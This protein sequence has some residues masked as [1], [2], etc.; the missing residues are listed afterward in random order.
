MAMRL[1]PCHRSLR[2]KTTST[3]FYPKRPIDLLLNGSQKII[4]INTKAI[5]NFIELFWKRGDI[6]LSLVFTQT[7]I[8]GRRCLHQSKYC[9]SSADDNTIFSTQLL[10]TTTRRYQWYQ[11][12]CI[13]LTWNI[14]WTDIVSLDN[15]FI[16]GNQRIMYWPTIQRK[17]PKGTIHLR[18]NAEG[19]LDSSIKLDELRRLRCW[20]TLCFVFEGG[21]ELRGAWEMLALPKMTT[22]PNLVTLMASA[23]K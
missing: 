12:F 6:Y 2:A 8:T 1:S 20:A 19:N 3:P 22:P 13:L 15:V 23:W 9:A 14:S 11:R 7:S 18:T 4:I 10:Q 17:T 5:K 21:V 16:L